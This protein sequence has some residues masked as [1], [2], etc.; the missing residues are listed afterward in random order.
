MTL[1]GNKILENWVIILFCEMI[2]SNNTFLWEYVEQDN[3]K[4]SLA[5]ENPRPLEISS[6]LVISVWKSKKIVVDKF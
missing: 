2:L 5:S 3:K 1:M 6:V 4:W